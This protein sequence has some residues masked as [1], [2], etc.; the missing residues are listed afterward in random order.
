MQIYRHTSKALDVLLSREERLVYA[1][2]REEISDALLAERTLLPL[3]TLRG[4][5][6]RLQAQGL[7]EAVASTQD[8]PRSKPEEPDA[9]ALKKARLIA[10]LEAELG[11]K[12][13]KYRAEVERMQTQTEL[14]EWSLK[15]VLKLRLTISQKVA[16]ALEARIKAVFA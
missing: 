1:L 7:I 6:A 5:L 10:A 13:Q 2:C 8:A 11:E 15:L 16:E 12:A 3:D 9:L 4:I 14:E